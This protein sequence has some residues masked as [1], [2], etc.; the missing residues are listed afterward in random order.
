MDTFC[1]WA[2]WACVFYFHS[3][4]IEDVSWYFMECISVD[5]K[6]SCVCG[7]AKVYCIC[8]W[9][10][11]DSVHMKMDLTRLN[12]MDLLEYWSA[13][14]SFTTRFRVLFTILHIKLTILII[15]YLLTRLVK[16][17]YLILWTKTM[18]I[19]L[20]A[21]E[22]IIKINE[23]TKT[24]FIPPYPHLYLILILP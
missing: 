5:L 8:I 20:H 9:I 22:K 17:Y 3:Y 1:K 16:L 24:P 18:N 7:I 15:R 23:I 11:Y 6:R 13:R 2:S 21:W 10:L 19:P 12:E 4:K 14:F